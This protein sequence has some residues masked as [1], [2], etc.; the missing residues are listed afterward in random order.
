MGRRRTPDQLF[1]LGLPL[2][3]MTT[4]TQ[5]SL[6]SDG[7]FRLWTAVNAMRALCV[8]VAAVVAGTLFPTDVAVITG[9]ITLSLAVANASQV[10]IA[11]RVQ[12]VSLRT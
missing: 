10:L 6:Q 5:S 2:H 3:L 11:F 9:M 7:R 12:G 1:S 8:A 4:V